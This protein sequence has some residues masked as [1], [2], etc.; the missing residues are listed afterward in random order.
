MTDSPAN[1]V[2]E[3]VAF[4]SNVLGRS[5]STVVAY[6]KSL[7]DFRRRMEIE[8]FAAVTIRDAD[9]YMARLALARRSPNT[10]R[11]R[12]SALKAFY[13]S[14]ASR[15]HIP[16]NPL[17]LARAPEEKRRDVIPVFSREEIGR[18]VFWQRPLVPQRRKDPAVLFNRRSRI[19][20]RLRDKPSGAAPTACGVPRIGRATRCFWRPTVLSSPPAGLPAATLCRSGLRVR[21]AWWPTAAIA[22]LRAPAAT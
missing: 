20:T 21:P 3:F 8:N 14:L 11:L 6:R 22:E 10:R 5:E 9:S 17:R 2:E 7:A 4:L 19:P 12:M 13:S 15:G 18:I 1:L 16:E